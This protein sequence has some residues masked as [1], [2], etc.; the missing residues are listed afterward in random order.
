[1]RKYFK[2]AYCLEDFVRYLR[3]NYLKLAV[4][5][6]IYIAYL[7]ASGSKTL[8]RFSIRNILTKTLH[9]SFEEKSKREAVMTFY[10]ATDAII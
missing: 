1:M 4:F 7:H 3:Y 2:N 10:H 8:V 6:I 5:H 9:R